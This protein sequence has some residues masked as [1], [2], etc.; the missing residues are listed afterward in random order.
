MD[1]ATAE[2]TMPL[3][4]QAEDQGAKEVDTS[5]ARRPPQTMDT[6]DG[7]RCATLN[8]YVLVGITD[9]VGIILIVM[10]AI[11]MGHYRGGFA[12]DGTGK[13]FNYHPV[14]MVLS[15]VYLYGNGEPLS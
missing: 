8:F 9:V 3:S 12:W 1:S 2:E 13:E 7:D 6:I 14:F 5:Q 15:L 11:W 10:V 4:S